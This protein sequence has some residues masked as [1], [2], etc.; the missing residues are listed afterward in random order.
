MQNESNCTNSNIVP[1]QR[2]GA[3][4]LDHTRRQWVDLGVLVEA[5]ITRPETCGVAGAAVALWMRIE[6]PDSSDYR[7]VV[8]SVSSNSQASF[9]FAKR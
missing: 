1:D 4:S 3:V 9:I 8:S 6:Y 7:G 2:K 5:C